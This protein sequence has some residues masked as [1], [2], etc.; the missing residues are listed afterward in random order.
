MSPGSGTRSN[1]P[2]EPEYLFIAICLTPVFAQHGPG[3][4]RHLRHAYRALELA[5]RRD[6]MSKLLGAPQHEGRGHAAPPAR[7]K[8][9]MG[10]QKTQRREEKQGRWQQGAG[11]ARRKSR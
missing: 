3:D 1:R 11:A 5:G 10:R 9:A 2:F 4:A 6:L 8:Q 7:Q